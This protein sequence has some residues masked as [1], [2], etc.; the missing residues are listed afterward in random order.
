[1]LRSG[2]VLAALCMTM[3]APAASA[4]GPVITVACTGIDGP[5]QS[6]ICELLQSSMESTWP[7]AN[8]VPASD[9]GSPAALE[10]Q[11]T[12]LRKEVDF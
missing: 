7:G 11:F 10:L 5:T 1:M 12:L 2:S 6:R 3:A 4:S 8:V 9:H